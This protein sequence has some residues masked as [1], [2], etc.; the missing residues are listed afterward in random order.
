MG[1]FDMDMKCAEVR[2]YMKAKKYDKAYDVLQT[3]D[4][5]KVKSIVDLK[6]FFE[7]YNN[8]KLYNNAKEMLVR[9]YQKNASKHVLYQLV[10]LELQAGELEKAEASYEDYIRYCEGTD[11]AYILRYL[12]D[13]AKH[14][15]YSVRIH[16]LEQ[17]KKSN[18]YEE[19][20]FELAKTYHKAGDA[21]S[22]IK[23]CDDIILWFGEGVIVEKAKLLRAYYLEGDTSFFTK[24]QIYRKKLDSVEKTE[25][26]LY[27]TTDLGKQISDIQAFDEEAKLKKELKQDITL[28]QDV[29]TN[30]QQDLMEDIKALKLK[31]ADKSEP[32][33][34]EP[35]KRIEVG[36][37]KDIETVK[38][39]RLESLQEAIQEILAK[40]EPQE[41]LLVGEWN[42]T[43]IF[44]HYTKQ[45]GTRKDLKNCFEKIQNGDR[46]DYFYVTTENPIQNLDFVKR[47]AKALQKAGVV[48]KSQ[49]ARIKGENL[50]HI[51]L[52]Q[53][54]DKLRNSILLIEGV[55]S[56]YLPTV[57][58]L[59]ELMEQLQNEIIIVFEDTRENVKIFQEEQY[60]LNRENAYTIHI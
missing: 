2:K 36:E 8:L 50:N 35:T 17:L 19:W 52:E 6:A 40:E 58:A 1:K 16:S 14:A 49:V 29:Q 46:I 13:K 32:E 38:A 59:I 31:I 5:T 7:V 51:Q 39:L 22:C 42:L 4:M 30:M 3:I 48:K 15:D 45:Q 24:P 18:Y 20:A 43:Q 44:E 25:G 11:D 23:E 53:R 21:E 27:N 47:L 28:T 57:K 12:I 37:E 34:E 33:I 10:C 55:D 41:E 60:K 56:L 9:I 54:V 26:L